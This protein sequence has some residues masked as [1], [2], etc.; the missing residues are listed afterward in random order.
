M[1]G[2]S[3]T[4]FCTDVE[5]DEMENKSGGDDDID[6]VQEDG[7]EDEDEEGRHRKPG[8]AK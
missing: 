1:V 4:S 6:D 3:F 8:V 7:D 2:C 5:D